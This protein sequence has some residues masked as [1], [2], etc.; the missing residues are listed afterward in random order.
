MS[1]SEFDLDDLSLADQIRAEVEALILESERSQRP[2]EME[3]LRSKLFEQFV[4]AQAAGYLVE[5]AAE[6]LTADGLMHTLATKW[7]LRSAAQSS[8]RENAPLPPE[9]LTRMRGLWAMMRMWMEWTYAWGRW[10]EFHKT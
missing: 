2:L 3:P 10:D 9:H 5:E 7:G 6:D 8:V 1:T 4:L